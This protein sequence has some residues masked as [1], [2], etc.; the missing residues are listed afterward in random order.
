MTPQ[1][2]PNRPMMGAIALMLLTTVLAGCSGDVTPSATIQTCDEDACQ[3]TVAEAPEALEIRGV[4]VDE[5]ITPVKGV[6]VKLFQGTEQLAKVNTG[7]NGAF[8]FLG[9]A[10]GFY[11]LTA[12]REGYDKAETQVDL[13]IGGPASLR[14]Q[15]TAR[16]PIVPIHTLIEWDGFVSCSTYT[17][18]VY[19]SAGCGFLS[20]VTGNPREIDRYRNF[21]DETMEPGIAPDWL[22]AELYWEA[23]QIAGEGLWLHPWLYNPD[24]SGRKS[25]RGVEGTSPL[26]LAMDGVAIHEHGIGGA[27]NVSMPHAMGY[28]IWAG[29]ADPLT[30]SIVIEQPFT[31][32]FS[33]LYHQTPPEGWMFIRDG[34]L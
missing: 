2:T 31:M 1:A 7:S 22:Q 13:Q 26:M 21:W 16:P 28:G 23:N 17:I 29:S 5:T 11:R 33:L 10:D 15:I 12:Q 32:Y 9:L 34:E 24:Q 20:I 27:T 4:V 25:L 19:V 18:V 14:M 3:I 8:K 30:P 6:T